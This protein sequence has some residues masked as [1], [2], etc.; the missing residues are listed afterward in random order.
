MK[1]VLFALPLLVL[2]SSAF[3]AG[4]AGLSVTNKSGIPMD[5]LYASPAGKGAFGENLMAGVKDG[6]LDKGKTA[7]L[8]AL[9]DGTYDFKVSAPDEGIECTIK[10]VAVKG[11]KIVFTPKE[12]KACK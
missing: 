7:V 11:S 5:E 10:G 6:A 9:A 1:R 2:A 12:G 4:A 8:A 3:A